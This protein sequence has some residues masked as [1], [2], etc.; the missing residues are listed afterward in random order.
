MLCSISTYGLNIFVTYPQCTLCTGCDA[1]FGRRLR[2]SNVASRGPRKTQGV[3]ANAR[4]CGEFEGNVGLSSLAV[5]GQ[6]GE[7]VLLNFFFCVFFLMK[8]RR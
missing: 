2:T 6:Q 3:G 7:Y 1:A 5:F 8:H 4:T